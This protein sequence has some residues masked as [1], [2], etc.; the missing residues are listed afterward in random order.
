MAKVRQGLQFVPVG[1]RCPTCSR[2]IL[3]SSLK[4]LRPEEEFPLCSSRVTL[5]PSGQAIRVTRIF[6]FTSATRQSS[7]FV[8]VFEKN[9]NCISSL[10]ETHPTTTTTER[11]EEERRKEKKMHRCDSFFLSFQICLVHRSDRRFHR[12]SSTSP[13]TKHTEAMLSELCTS[14]LVACWILSINAL[15]NEDFYKG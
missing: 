7:L 14:L 4:G 5:S 6:L 15:S 10:H 3:P 8:F 12:I 2:T 11:R 9:G 13:R 1:I